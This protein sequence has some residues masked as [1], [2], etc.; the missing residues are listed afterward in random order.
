M[1]FPVDEGN[2][3]GFQTLMSNRVV[4]HLVES[5]SEKII[6]HWQKEKSIIRRNLVDQLTA[7]TWMPWGRRAG[8]RSTS[9]ASDDEK[10]LTDVRCICLTE[11]WQIKRLELQLHKHL[12]ASW[13]Q[14]KNSWMPWERNADSYTSCE[15]RQLTFIHLPLQCCPSLTCQVFW[16]QYKS[17]T[18]WIPASACFLWLR[19]WIT[20]IQALQWPPHLECNQLGGCSPAL[21]A[22][23]LTKDIH[24]LVSSCGILEFAA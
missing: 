6:S 21:A 20:W 7:P 11:C 17:W 13:C 5:S 2:A 16:K 9:E 8:A 15:L 19:Q 12:H 18:N 3:H 1:Y 23:F 14:I 4:P 22:L 24:W 10:S